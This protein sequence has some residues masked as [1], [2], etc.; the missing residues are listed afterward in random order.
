MIDSEFE[1]LLRTC[2]IELSH[3]EKTSLKKDIEE[4]IDYFNSIDAINVKGLDAAYHPVPVPQKTHADEVEEF[5]DVSGLLGNTK[6]YRFYV[7]GPEI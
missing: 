3:A 7:V 2:R 1:A 6:T 5:A 4:L